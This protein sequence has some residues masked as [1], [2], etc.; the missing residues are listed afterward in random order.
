MNKIINPTR[1]SEWKFPPKAAVVFSEF[2]WLELGLLLLSKSASLYFVFSSGLVCSIKISARFES[3]YLTW[4]VSKKFHVGTS[5]AECRAIWERLG[6]EKGSLSLPNSFP[7]D[8]NINFIS[9]HEF[10]I[11]IITFD[12]N[13]VIVTPKNFFR[14]L[15]EKVKRYKTIMYLISKWRRN[16]YVISLCVHKTQLYIYYISNCTHAMYVFIKI[17]KNSQR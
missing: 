13:N 8:L 3:Y 2:V 1:K 14:Y 9:K 15:R 17:L 6:Q 11:V 10:D 5:G 4:R 7:T 16:E 12:L